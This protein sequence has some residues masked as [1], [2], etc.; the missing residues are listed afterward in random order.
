M[1]KIL[2]LS[3]SGVSLGICIGS[4]LPYP[5]HLVT[6]LHTLCLQHPNLLTIFLQIL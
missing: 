4:L 1:K 5:F 2:N 3:L 6:K